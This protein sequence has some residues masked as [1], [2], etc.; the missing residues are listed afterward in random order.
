MS[1][2][3][4]YVGVGIAVMVAAFVIFCALLPTVTP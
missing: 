1:K 2:D 3:L 4:T